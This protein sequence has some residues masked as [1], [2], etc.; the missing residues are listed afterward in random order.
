MQRLTLLLLLTVSWSIVAAQAP[1]IDEELEVRRYAVEIVIFRYAEEISVGTELF[2]PDRPPAEEPIE[3]ISDDDVRGDDRKIKA[4]Q[5][6]DLEMLL[7]TDDDFTMDGVVRRFEQLDVYETI[8]H[9]GWTQATYP[10]EETA[11]IDLRVLRVPPRGLDGSFSLYLGRFLH[12]VVDLAL[13]ERAGVNQPAAI[14]RPTS[15]Y[16]DYRQRRDID[17]YG[18]AGPVR[19]RIRENRIFKNG[20]IRYF[21]HP[22]FGVIAKITRVEEDETEELVGRTGQ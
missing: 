5:L 13:D 22:K 9:V 15:N 14:D 3:V 20:E 21:D 11:A 6:R 10:P 17:A 2:V 4:P 8:Y 7:F 19:Y 12:L 16:S 1:L 18:D